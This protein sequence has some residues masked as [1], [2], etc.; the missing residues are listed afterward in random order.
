VQ[1]A[2]VDLGFQL[3]GMSGTEWPQLHVQPGS[4]ASLDAHLAPGDEVVEVGGQ[5]APATFEGFLDELI[6]AEGGRVDLVVA[7]DGEEY[8]TAVDVPV[9]SE[10]SGLFGVSA[11]R[12]PAEPFGALEAVPAAGGEFARITWAATSGLASFFS[13]SGLSGFTDQVVSTPPAGEESAP[14]PALD[15][16]PADPALPPLPEPPASA[17]EEDRVHSILGIITIGSQLDFVGVIYLVAVLNIFLAL[18]NLI[19]LLPFDGGHIAVATYER[20]RE[21]L[22]KRDLVG[23]RLQAGRYL[24][25][26]GKLIPVTYAVVALVVAVGLGALYLDAVDPASVPN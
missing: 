1:T 23:A 2:E 12:P 11:Y 18:F 25:D 19:P 5:P 8:A 26:F 14:P 15:E 3:L 21:G 6:A 24:A 20:I 9:G 7:R 17:L 13:P 22:A 16:T 4:P 10:R